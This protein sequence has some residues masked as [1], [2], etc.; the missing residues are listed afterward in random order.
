MT[1]RRQKA[2]GEMLAPIRKASGLLHQPLPKKNDIRRTW[3]C[4]VPT[5]LFQPNEAEKGHCEAAMLGM[6]IQSLLTVGLFPIPHAT[7][8]PDSVFSLK[9]RLKVLSVKGS[10]DPKHSE[11][12]PIRNLAETLDTVTS[13]IK[14]LTTLNQ[15]RHLAAQAKKSGIAA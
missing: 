13:G 10:C 6:L 12:K 4:S 1:Q 14:S 7:T 5:T 3:V 8:F 15:A 11:C 9:S 2:L